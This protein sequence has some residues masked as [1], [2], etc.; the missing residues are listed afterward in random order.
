MSNEENTSGALALALVAFV[1]AMVN[2]VPGTLFMAY[3][4]SVVWNMF[5]GDAWPTI[6]TAMA[7]GPMLVVGLV[8]YQVVDCQKPERTTGECVV[9]LMVATMRPYIMGGWFMLCAWIISCF[10]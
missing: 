1:L 2:M 3:S 8:T 4:T 5:A 9:H 7:I 6:T 10:I